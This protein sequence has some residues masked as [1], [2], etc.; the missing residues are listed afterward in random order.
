MTPRWIPA[1]VALA[2]PVACA[3]LDT[4]LFDSLPADEFRW[5]DDP[6]DPQL[7][8]DLSENY[9]EHFGGPE[10]TC[11]PSKIPPQDRTEGFVTA[12]DGNE[13]HYVYAERPGADTTIFYSHGRKHHIGVYWERVELM[14]E[15]GYNVMIY[16]Y[17][18]FGRSSGEPDEASLYASAEAVMELLP[19]MPGVDVDRVFFYGFSLGGGPTYEMGARGVRDELPIRP[20]GLISESTFCSVEALVQDG[21][22][23]NLS[24]EFLS[25]NRFDNCSK[26]DE[27]AAAIPV[28]IVHGEVDDFVTPVH[29]QLLLA[30]TDE[31]VELHW[32]EGSAHSDIPVLVPD[33]YAQWLTEFLAQ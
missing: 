8:G 14:W 2:L 27:I 3:T 16:D 21:S 17:P 32:A 24:A 13:I 5:D 33:E 9:Y 23:T 19:G 20:R 18:G 6:C 25:E 11:H 31:D 7:T 22:Y 28:M 10:P 1:A 12:A 30:A 15:L 26:I 29:A 4:F